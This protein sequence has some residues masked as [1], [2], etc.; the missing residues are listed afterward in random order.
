MET[1]KDVLD[2]KGRRVWSVR[3][4][5]TVERALSVLNEANIGAL[6]VMTDSGDLVGVFSERDFARKALTHGDAVMETPV[7]ELMSTELRSATPEM[8]IE[9]SMAVMTAE[10]IRHL[11]V[12]SGDRLEGLV[13]IG[14]VVKAMVQEKNLVIDQLEHYIESSL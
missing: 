6:L 4:D 9:Q 8:T 11:P 14:D 13:S 3:P 2:A 12:F 1:L 7:R 5:D 10:R